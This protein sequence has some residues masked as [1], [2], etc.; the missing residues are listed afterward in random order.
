[1]KVLSV[2]YNGTNAQT[3][4]N[5]LGTIIRSGILFITMPIFTRLLGAEQYGLFSIYASWLTIFSCTMGLNVKA[6]LGTGYY[7]FND[8]Y[9][10]FR[11]STLIEGTAISTVMITG[12]LLTSNIFMKVLGYPFF[13]ILLLF[14][15]SFAQFVIEFANLSWIYE[16]HAGRNMVLAL[17]T[18]LFT[19]VLSI[20]ILLFWRGTRDH[21]YFGRIIGTAVPQILVAAILWI[22]MFKEK[23]AGYNAVYWKYSFFFG[24]P[25]VFHLLSQQILGQSDKIMMQM[26]KTNGIEIGIYSFFYGLVSILNTVLGA[27]NNSWCP[28]L[29][30]DLKNKDYEQL[31]KKVKNYVQIFTILSLG[32]LMVSREITKL[33]SNEEYWPG[34]PVIPILVLV[35]YFTFIYQFAVNYEIFNAK[36]KFVA[37]GTV[38]AALSNILFNILLIPSFGMYGAAIA[39]LLSYIILAVMHT[40]VVNTWKIEKYPLVY[41]P[42]WLGLVLVLSGCVLFYVTADFLL[43]RWTI[44]I[45]LGIH[46]VVSVYRR[47]TI[48]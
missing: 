47:K 37:I 28:F 13:I 41:Q 12:V 31:N 19:S 20:L 25:M 40:V 38:V 7:K 34:M 33:F 3:F 26:F 29:Y 8:R 9:Y 6:G 35:I 2:K 24:L 27:L 11:S 39:T 21:L 48:F 42:V 10:E 36:P 15:E 4:F 43:I 17:S 16:K 46:L 44:G 23:P 1:M 5:F 14:L 22:G 45:G 30:D 32:F 18:L